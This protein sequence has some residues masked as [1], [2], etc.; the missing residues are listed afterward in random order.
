[1]IGIPIQ[2]TRIQWNVSVFFVW[3]RCV[4]AGVDA[5]PFWTFADGSTHS[6]VMS[7]SDTGR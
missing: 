1:M 4:E 6:G 3:L 5:I 2:T 7:V